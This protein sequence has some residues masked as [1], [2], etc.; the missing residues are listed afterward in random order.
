MKYKLGDICEEIREKILTSDLS[1]QE[2]I[3]T[4]NMIVNRGGVI[5]AVSLP[6]SKKVQSF[7]CGDVL[8]SNIRPYFKKIWHATFEGGCSN[9][10]LVFRAKQG[11]SGKF[12]YYTL[13][14]DAF[15]SYATSTAKGTKMP[16]GDKEAI[17]EYPV[18]LPSY[19]LQ[20]KRVIL[21]CLF[22][23][24]INYSNQIN[25]NL[26]VVVIVYSGKQRRITVKVYLVLIQQP[27]PYTDRRKRKTLTMC[28]NNFAH[29]I[30][31]AA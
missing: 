10:V 15:F 2:Y 28:H 1:E 4:D 14:D 9:D 6:S 22:D 23:E 8:V 18:D 19:E 31:M 16:R 3:S 17:M 20:E 29:S 27:L 5:D 24:L 11:V 26:Y 12:L 30:Q 21:P 7:K 13:S 25:K